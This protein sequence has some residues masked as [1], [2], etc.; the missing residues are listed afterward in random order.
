MAWVYILTSRAMPGLVKI[1]STK[2]PPEERARQLSTTAVRRPSQRQ[3]MGST[4]RVA[5]R[6]RFLFR[7]SNSAADCETALVAGKSPEAYPQNTGVDI[8]DRGGPPAGPTGMHRI[9]LP[10]AQPFRIK[11]IGGSAQRSIR[12]SGNRQS[13][14]EPRI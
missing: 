11:V 1:G 13:R 2:L 3:R 9:R 10:P 6:N 4:A 12:L 14:T 5:F 7:A 8:R